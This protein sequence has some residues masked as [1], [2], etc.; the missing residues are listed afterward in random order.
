[1]D[2]NELRARRAEMLRLVNQ[3]PSS[4]TGYRK[5]IGGAGETSYALTGRLVFASVRNAAFVE[6]RAEVPELPVAEY[7]WLVVTTYDE[8]AIKP[9]DELDIV[10]PT[11]GR[12]RFIVGFVVRL[13]DKQEAL[14]KELG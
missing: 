2:T 7:P 8:D 11:Y 1:M 4:I 9:K 12:R 6:R 10:S 3:D 13:E 14:C 5:G